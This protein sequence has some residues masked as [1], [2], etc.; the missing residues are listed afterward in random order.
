MRRQVAACSA[1]VVRVLLGGEPAPLEGADAG[2][3]LA[4]HPPLK[5]SLLATLAATTPFW[6]ASACDVAFYRAVA[7]Q[8]QRASHLAT[9]TPHAAPL[10]VH[11]PTAGP[12]CQRPTSWSGAWPSAPKP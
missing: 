3:S 2:H 11:S 8:L 5:K 7:P 1:E 12:A 10:L 4:L 9:T 6:C